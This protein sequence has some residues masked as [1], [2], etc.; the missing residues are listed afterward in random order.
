MYVGDG[1]NRWVHKE[2]ETRPNRVGGIAAGAQDFEHAI[3]KALEL[4]K[5]V[6]AITCRV[7]AVQFQ[8]NKRFPKR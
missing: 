8:R 3:E 6:D 1:L 7:G 2:V 4:A 5:S